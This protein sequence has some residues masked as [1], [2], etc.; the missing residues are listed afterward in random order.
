MADFDAWDYGW[1]DDASEAASKLVDS[2]GNVVTDG[3]GQAITTGGI[4]PSGNVTTS[5]TP[6]AALGTAVVTTNVLPPAAIAQIVNGESTN[7]SAEDAAPVN[8]LAPYLKNVVKNPL[9]DFASYTPLWT[10]A[11]LTPEQFN[12]PAT[13]R[14]SPGDLKNIVFANAGRFD[15]Q[16]VNTF[17][18]SPEFY[19]DNFSMK[20]IVAATEKT[21]ATNAVQLSFEI[22][23]PYSMGLFLEALQNA[24]VKAG[25]G[26]TY[27]NA[28]FVLR[29][30]FKGW[31]EDATI[32]ESLKPKF[33]PI[34]ITKASFTVNEG[35]SVYDVEAV[36]FNHEA[37]GDQVNT[38]YK[39]SNFT[40]PE[41]GSVSEILVWG[42]KSL[43]N[44]LNQA[45]EDSVKSGQKTLA[46]V[47]EIQFPPKAAAS[48]AA[49]TSSSSKIIKDNGAT[50]SLGGRPD[51]RV[52]SSKST[53]AS[54]ASSEDYPGPIPE[55]TFGFGPDNGG[56]FPFLKEGEA[57]DAE[58]G[59]FKRDNLTIN[60]TDRSFTFT[61]G[62]RLTDIITNVILASDYG[63]KAIEPAN[64]TPEGNVKW[65][66]IDTQVELLDFEPVQNKHAKKIIF[67]IVPYEVHHSVWSNPGSAPVG[68]KKLAEIIAKKYDY[69]YTGQNTSVLKFDIEIN[70]LFYAGMDPSKPDE[71]P[72][73]TNNDLNGIVQQDVPET[74]AGVP[75]DPKALNPKTQVGAPGKNPNNFNSPIK[76]G[77]GK[78][79]EALIAEN[80]HRAI[81]EKGT[82]DMVNINITI[83]GDPYWIV[84]SGIGNYYST[85]TVKGITDDGTMDYEGNDVYIYAVFRTPADL[86]TETGLFDYSAL[87]KVNPFS[88]IYKVISVQNNFSSGQFTQQLKCIR[89][90]QQPEDFDPENTPSAP[91]IE[92]V[93]PTKATGN[94]KTPVE[95]TERPA[96]AKPTNVSVAQS[97][98]EAQAAFAGFVSTASKANALLSLVEGSSPAALFASATSGGNPL[99][100]LLGT[101]P[102]IDTGQFSAD[103]NSATAALNSAVPNASAALTSAQGNISSAISDLQSG[104]GNAASNLTNLV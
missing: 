29:L 3:F 97:V 63:K 9:D 25:Y 45:E 59:I 87:E 88:G 20:T 39:D 76:G 104:V 103:L 80:F 50:M 14:N 90:P 91:D 10:L 99:G 78:T 5:T 43:V 57:V 36:P 46:D 8:S 102:S 21:G 83:V 18:G 84:D 75:S 72:D 98:Q 93:F 15:G 94:T 13:Y 32:R 74:G 77:A 100:D 52:V 95:I 79:V 4:T 92:N 81:L 28:P 19:V 26:Y 64:L 41:K 34:N 53:T 55:S 86:N 51:E 48:G 44:T 11:C 6:S 101:A 17:H 69:I 27:A 33:F 67:R 7:T 38:L 2:D 56:N 65:F 22:T 58:T 71:N 31:D 70:N 16:R 30:D 54:S 66:K 73:A 37:L 35:G 23:E 82:G 89:M 96:E 68:Y 61:Q 49:A 1:V 40:A 62:Q 42:E 60:T 47:Y 12:D 24:S 85:S